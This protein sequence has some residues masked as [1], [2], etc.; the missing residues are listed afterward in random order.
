LHGLSDLAAQ[1][2][3]L[4]EPTVLDL[5]HVAE[6]IRASTESDAAPQ[7]PDATRTRGAGPTAGGRPARA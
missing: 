4:V 5:A 1:V 2:G 7:N 6:G 3:Q